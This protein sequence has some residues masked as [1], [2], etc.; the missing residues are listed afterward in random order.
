MVKTTVTSGPYTGIVLI[1]PHEVCQGSYS[2]STNALENYYR[3]VCLSSSSA[4]VYMYAP[5]PAFSLSLSLSSRG[6]RATGRHARS[7]G[8]KIHLQAHNCI[9]CVDFKWNHLLGTPLRTR[10]VVLPPRGTAHCPF[11]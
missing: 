6:L 5:L 9:C 2:D 1:E 10:H 8:L 11:P 4:T 7:C 3:V